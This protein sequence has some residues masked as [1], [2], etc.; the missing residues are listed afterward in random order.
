V[1]DNIHETY[2]L[3]TAFTTPELI[4]IRD[5]AIH[6]RSRDPSAIPRSAAHHKKIRHGGGS[7]EM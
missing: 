3:P 4:S 5:P 6:P 2:R 7:K 1:P